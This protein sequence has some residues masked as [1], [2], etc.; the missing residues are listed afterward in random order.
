MLLKHFKASSRTFEAFQVDLGPRPGLERPVSQLLRTEP[1][2][3]E[4]LAAPRSGRDEPKGRH[5]RRHHAAVVQRPHPGD[6]AQPGG[7]VA[8]QS[9]RHLIEGSSPSLLRYLLIAY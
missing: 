6:L 2:I 1:P 3:G 5:D 4:R 9:S 7:R 8:F